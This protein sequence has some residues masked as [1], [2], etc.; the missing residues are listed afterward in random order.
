MESPRI[1]ETV[2]PAR[3]PESGNIVALIVGEAPGPRG[4]DKSSHPWWGDEA[5]KLLFKALHRGGFFRSVRIT[6][7]AGLFQGEAAH[8]PIGASFEDCPHLSPW[9]GR[10]FAEEG[11][12]PVLEGV[13]LSNAWPICPTGDGKTFHR[14]KEAQMAS[15]EN[16]RRMLGELATCL[17]RTPGSPLRVVALGTA[18]AWF[19]GDCLEIEQDPNVRLTCLP[20]PAPQGVLAWIRKIQ[21]ENGSPLTVPEARERWIESLLQALT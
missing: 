4:A 6:P 9:S 10:R 8:V 16:K 1:H 14:P 11:I 2:V 13:A 18:A 3:F 15:P 21:K 17:S 12:L 20:H 5:G 19:L 7:P